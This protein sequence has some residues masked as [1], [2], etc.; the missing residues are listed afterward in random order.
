ME[1][2]VR[3]KFTR[4]RTYE[5]YS[6]P[7]ETRTR[8]W[9]TIRV[10]LSGLRWESF[11]QNGLDKIM[12]EARTAMLKNNPDPPSNRSALETLIQNRQI[13][14][15]QGNLFDVEPLPIESNLD[16]NKIEGMM[17]GL[18]IGDA[19]G[20]TSED[21]LPSVRAAKYGEIGD[22][23]PNRHAENRR[24]GLPSDDTQLACWTLESMLEDARFVPENVARR[25]ASGRQ[26][27][28]LGS[29]VRQFLRNRK[30][31]SK[32]WYT[33]GPESAGN[34]A[35]MRIAPILIPYLR[36]PSA[37]L[38]IDAALSGL[39][40]HN[41]SASLSACVAFVNM[42]WHLLPM[43]SA[44]EPIWWLDT[45]VG[46]AG[47][48]ELS[49][50][51]RPRGGSFI[52]YSGPIWRFVEQVVSD[53]YRRNL[54]AVEACQSWYS[55]AYLLET[56]PSVIYILMRHGHDFEEAVVRAVND[57]KDNDTI[58]AIVGAAV[59]ALHGKPA[60]PDKWLK[61]LLGRTSYDDD[62]RVCELL[63]RAR[64]LWWDS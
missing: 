12:M 8:K 30:E 43:K 37:D 56:V 32:P 36:H 16:F 4:M 21:M 23:Q 15:K 26:I 58:A 51:Y 42:L 3:A 41:D 17:L 53:A 52:D 40:T 63:G 44:P 64:R 18:A 1:A 46:S 39:I 55:G 29:S 33:C 14:L 7:W 59:G 57:T 22:Y 38:W 19:L 47:E 20:N 2:G 34:G 9:P 11:G 50:Q 54:S 24:V 45:Y 62:G 61:G 28:G 6:W 27:F 31:P 13:R 35:L 49:Q 25:F 60:I 10:H 5:E 48:L